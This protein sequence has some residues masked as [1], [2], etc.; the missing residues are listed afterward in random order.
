MKKLTYEEA[1]KHVKK[2]GITLFS[3]YGGSS[4]GGLQDGTR[5]YIGF[6][7]R[8]LSSWDCDTE[9]KNQDFNYD[10][11]YCWGFI[12]QDYNYTF[13]LV[14]EEPTLT[15]KEL[16]MKNYLHAYVKSTCSLNLITLVNNL[17][18]ESHE[19]ALKAGEEIKADFEKLA[20]KCKSTVKLEVEISTKL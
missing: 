10:F 5:L 13:E 4:R 2:H 11:D 7:D 14:E 16:N 19:E 6:D 15:T 17:E 12:C 3:V 9:N 20:K 8:W 18:F 1:L